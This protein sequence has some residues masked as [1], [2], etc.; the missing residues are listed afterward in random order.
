MRE[1][2]VKKILYWCDNC[3]VPLIGRTCACGARSREIPLLQP[4]DVRPAL[5]ADMALIRGLL[6][7]QF[8]DIPL[9][10]VVLLNKTGGTDRADLVIVHGD[11]FGWLMFDPVTRQFSLD[12][13]PEALPYILPHATR[14]IV[15][16]EAEHAVNAHKGRIGGKRF[17]LSTPVPDGT[18]IVSYKNRFGTG[19]VKDGQVRVKELV[20]VEPRTRPDPGWDV[21]I[22]KNRYHLKNL[23]RNAVRTI[24]K[25]MNDR[26][27]VNVSFSGGKD[28]TAAL[29]LARKA[30]VEKA[31][32]IDTGI[33]LPETVE[34]VA[35]QGVEIIRKGGDF[36]QAVE[37]AGPPGKDLRWCCKLLKL[38]PL[39]IYLS[40][41]GPCVT[42]QG[43]RWYESWNRADLDE[44]SQNPAN[45]LQLNVSPI[46]NWR[47]LEVFLYLWWRKAPINPL[48]EKGL[49]RIGCY[50]CPAALESEY[51]GLRKMH[52]E[53]TERWDGFLERWAK[54]TGMPD[55]YHQ[56]GL[57]RWRALPPKMRELCRDRGIPLNDDFT[58]QA[59]PV[60]ELIEVAEMETARSCEPAS[61]A[62]KEFSAEEIR[63]DFP[64]LGDII[65][66]DNAATSFSP[67]PVV[68]ALVE[69]EHRYRANVGRGIHR[70]TQIATQRYWHAHEK[71][72][73]FIGGEAGVTIFT[74]NT[75]EA[76][77]MVAQGLSWKPGDRVVTTILEHHSNLL[78]WRALGKQ[79]VSLDVI[80]INADYSLDLAALEESLE[81]GGV[82]LVAVTHASNVL[83]VTTPVPEIARMCQKHGAL[84]LVDAAQSLPHM[85][86]DVSQLGCDFLC[87][88]G[89]KVFGPTGTGVLWM[90]EAILEPQV[91]GGGMVES[92]T[93]EGYVPAEGYQRYEAGTPNVGGG[94]AL[95]VAVDYLSAIGMERIHQYEERLT[96]RLIDGLSRI[97][98]VRVYAS[99][100]AGS[101]IGV[102]SFTIDGIH[103]QEAAHLLD[104]E[105]DILVR[106]GHHCCQP[107][108]EHLGLPNGTVRASLAA[109]TTEQEIDLLLAAVGEISRGR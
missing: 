31:F 6:A 98:G 2:A 33:E 102:V 51:E 78:P 34:F 28:S 92:V 59:A 57:W 70:L 47:A 4:Y 94:I 101:R 55:A 13:A 87:F 104:E 7:A 44:T 18:V 69:F 68:E 99:R 62:G 93:S 108:M 95:G 96:A 43:N 37:K 75:T 85:P 67:E 46:R 30:G 26:P 52:P 89:H 41:V 12:I 36:F 40:G 91:L 76:I 35:S 53:L 54:K 58:L 27:C 29:H 64:I 90:R 23:E 86:V 77:N 45:P 49:E 15:D 8:G 73:R 74:K 105:A 24:R 21:V 71:V 103:P 17:P 25:H 22:G 3:N 79:G 42:I 88:S 50:L 39:K 5:A 84:L 11:R 32:F 56:W 81:R 65:Y 66:L 109:Y 100:R 97:D 61:P 82:R 72:A 19:V 107:L 16:L 83:G 9:P 80:G 48:Y 20:P 60:K 14:G 10:G 63:R 38:H 1:P 106:S